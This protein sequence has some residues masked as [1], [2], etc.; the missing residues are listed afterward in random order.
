MSYDQF[1]SAF[2]RECRRQGVP[3]PS[4]DPE[5]RSFVFH[6]ASGVS[7]RTATA[8][9]F[10]QWQ[11]S[12]DRAGMV[13]DVVKSYGGLDEAVTGGPGVADLKPGLRSRSLIS[14][15]QIEAQTRMPGVS[16][17]TLRGSEIASTPFCGE[18]AACVVR[19]ID[20]V[21]MMPMPRMLLDAA[22]LSF[23]QAMATAMAQFRASAPPLTFES[24]VPGVPGL[25]VCRSWGHFQAALLLMTPG[26]D[27]RF[28]PLGGGDPVA[29]APTRTFFFVTGSRNRQ[30]VSFLL[31]AAATAASQDDFLSPQLLTCHD[32]RWREYAFSAGTREAIIQHD[33]ACKHLLSGYARQKQLLDDLHRKQK[34][35][36]TVAPFT[37]VGSRTG[38]FSVT[39][40]TRDANATLVPVADR[41]GFVDADPGSASSRSSANAGDAFRVRWSAAMA[42]AGHLFEEVP[43]LYPP[44]Y[45][46]LGFPD[47]GVMAKLRAKAVQ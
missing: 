3:P 37:V 32:G 21:T 28:P 39:T 44:R 33:V 13:A 45:R 27:F 8:G 9:M 1:V 22:G 7:S 4:H 24:L 38:D 20:G 5:E 6:G 30:G 16:E 47:A 2:M 29:L 18:L 35:D 34:Q 43:G 15:L 41:I 42:I 23:D 40:L 36:V 31:A 25:F 12:R 14:D 10:R 17:E 11:G 46:A 19:D 26:E